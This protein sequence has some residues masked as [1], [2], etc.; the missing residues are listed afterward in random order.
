MTWKMLTS[1]FSA[2]WRARSKTQHRQLGLRTC[3][4]RIG[5]RDLKISEIG[6]SLHGHTGLT[7]T[8]T[9]DQLR[10]SWKHTGDVIITVLVTTSIALVTSWAWIHFDT[11]ADMAYKVLRPAYSP[12]RLTTFLL[13]LLPY[14][15]C[16]TGHILHLAPLYHWYILLQLLVVR[17]IPVAWVVRWTGTQ[18][19]L[20]KHPVGE[21][22][23]S[24]CC[25]FSK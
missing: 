13:I 15:R 1:C 7:P 25:Y 23:I 21:P 9:S 14:P 3:T 16:V 11:V 8:D 2:Q 5:A 20:G 24:L 22:H 17:I 10:R 6:S 18:A 19:L 4:L 12:N